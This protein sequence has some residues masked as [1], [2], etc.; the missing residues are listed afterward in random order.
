MP[1]PCVFC[2][3]PVEED[4]GSSRH[5][6]A[7]G[8]VIAHT[9]C[10]RERGGTTREIRACQTCGYERKVKV[11]RSWDG[12]K[13]MTEHW[14]RDCTYCELIASAVTHERTA[15]RLRHKA[16]GIAMRRLA[17]ELRAS[18]KTTS[19]PPKGGWN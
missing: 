19:P 14:K 11:W 5:H 1:G 13:E 2:D 15:R 18:K 4:D 16:Q 8:I 17:Q 6:T 10:V 3:E 9:D 12:G 7:T